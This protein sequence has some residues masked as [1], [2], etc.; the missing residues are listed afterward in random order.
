[1][2]IAEAHKREKKG[3]EQSLQCDLDHYLH[4]LNIDQYL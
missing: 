4:N 1:M 2:V 3:S